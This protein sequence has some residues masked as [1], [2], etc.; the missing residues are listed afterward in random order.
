MPTEIKKTAVP[1]EITTPSNV[2]TGLGTLEFTDGYPT[3]RPRRSC[4]T[5]WTTCTA[6]RR[7]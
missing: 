4:V 3:E 7:S 6:S 2:E 1:A 5:T